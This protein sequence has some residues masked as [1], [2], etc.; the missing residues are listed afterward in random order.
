M[1]GVL[2]RIDEDEEQKTDQSFFTDPEENEG[3]AEMR[4]GE[5]GKDA[6][7]SPDPQT[8]TVDAPT[9][10]PHIGDGIVDHGPTGPFDRPNEEEESDSLAHTV[11]A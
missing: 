2:E 10:A 8:A 7:A 9:E 3:A 6:G 11:P 5:K 1:D 4:S